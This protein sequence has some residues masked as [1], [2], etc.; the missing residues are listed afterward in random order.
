DFFAVG[1]QLGL[2][3]HSL[4]RVVAAGGGEQR[5]RQ[6]QGNFS[7]HPFLRAGHFGSSSSTRATLL[8]PHS[9]SRSS[10]RWASSSLVVLT[11]TQR[12]WV[13]AERNSSTSNTGWC[14]RGNFHSQISPKKIDSA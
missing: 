11:E 1:E 9:R 10:A 12:A 13:E 2:V 3:L 6:R 5:N 7:P 4:E 8:A 14:G